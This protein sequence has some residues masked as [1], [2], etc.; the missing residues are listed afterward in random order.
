MKHLSYALFATCIS[1]FGGGGVQSLSR[2]QLFATSYDPTAAHQAFLSLT[3][4]WSL[5]KLMFIISD[6]IQPSHL[7]FSPAPPAL[8]LS[9][10]QCLFQ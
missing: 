9:Q 3:I 2:V 8:N 7:L 10:H 4:T 6:G 5:L 1:F